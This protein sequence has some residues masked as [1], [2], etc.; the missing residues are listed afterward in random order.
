MKAIVF[1]MDVKWMDK[2]ANLKKLADTALLHKGDIMVLPEMF[3]TGYI[4]NPENGAEKEGGS[5]IE[6]MKKISH[7]SGMLLCGSIPMDSSGGAT[8]TFVAVSDQ[9]IEARY[10]KIHLFTPSGEAKEYA[11]GHETTV[12]SVGEWNIRPLICYDLRFPYV[13]TNKG[14]SF[15]VLMYCANWPIARIQQWRA[16][17]V[18]RAIENQCYVIGVNRVGTDENGYE[19]SGNSLIIDY[20]GNILADA[21]DREGTIEAELDKAELMKYRQNLPFLEDMRLTEFA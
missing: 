19:Y 16:L 2:E 1:Q 20:K 15:D 17:L 18:A 8:N 9:G 21:G 10:D 3:N 5:T 7:D 6:V 11:S 13:S 14:K 4:M 12:F